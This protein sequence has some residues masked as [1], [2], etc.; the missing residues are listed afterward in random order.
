[1]KV[2]VIHLGEHAWVV[3]RVPGLPGERFQ[4]DPSRPY[5]P[6]GAAAERNYVSLYD[7]LDVDLGDLVSDGP[8]HP[9]VVVSMVGE[10][11]NAFAILGRV[12]KGL[13]DGGVEPEEVRAFVD[14]ATA[15]DYDELLATVMRWVTVE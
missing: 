4:F 11:G 9:D 14:E 10:D 8:K 2:R 6:V 3:R 15:G 13:R 5:V 12:Q 7:I 1:M